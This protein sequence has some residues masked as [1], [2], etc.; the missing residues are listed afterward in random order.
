M[1]AATDISDLALATLALLHRLDHADRDRL[2]HVADSKASER[3]VLGKRLDAHRLLRHHLDDRG[4]A[5]LDVRRV[6]LQLLSATTI[7]LFHEFAEL[8][9]DVRSVA[10]QD[11]RVAGVDLAR[12]IQYDHLQTHKKA[13]CCRPFPGF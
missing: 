6:V 10:V 11:W 5:G 8:A 3:S 9:R 1:T 12:V 4:V 7:D 13:H 2:T